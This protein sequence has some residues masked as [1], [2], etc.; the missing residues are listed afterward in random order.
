MKKKARRALEESIAH[1]EEVVADPVTER[2]GPSQCA[3]CH[4]YRRVEPLKIFS[5][6]TPTFKPVCDGCPVKERTGQ[7]ACQGTPYAEFAGLQLRT[8]KEPFTA[9]FSL[10]D[11]RGKAIEELDFL[12]SL[13]EE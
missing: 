11:L 7:D 3:L 10:A 9:L 4:K 5:L 1:W 2:I 6:R 8:S 13:R 12:V